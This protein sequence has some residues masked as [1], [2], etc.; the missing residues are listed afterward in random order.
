VSCFCCC[1]GSGK[2]SVADAV[3]NAIK[4]REQFPDY[5]AGLDIVG[6]EDAGPPLIDF[7]DVLLQSSQTL[8][9]FF[10]AGETSQ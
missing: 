9:Y 3:K 10:H 6:H 5:L 1:R 8:P 2:Q 7:I 4:L